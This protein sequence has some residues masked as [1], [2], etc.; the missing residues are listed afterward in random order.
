M[1]D[2][3]Q[4]VERLREARVTFRTDIVHGM[5]GDQALVEDPSGNAIELLRSQTGATA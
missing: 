3:P 1:A 4:Q 5:G 2:L